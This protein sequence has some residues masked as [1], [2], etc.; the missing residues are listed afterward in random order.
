MMDEPDLQPLEARLGYTFKDRKLLAMA[1]THPSATQSFVPDGCDN[2]RLEFLGDAVLQL[3][4]AH[5][6]YIRY[7][8]M[9]EG[10]LTKARARMV[11]ERTLSDMARKVDLGSELIMSRG[12][13]ANG[14]RERVSAL[15][16]A[17][18]AAV[19]AVYMDSDFPTALKVIECI[20]GA[21]IG[22]GAALPDID[23]PKGEL[24]E[25]VQATSPDAPVYR[26]ESAS[27]P[28]HDR[29]F[30]STVHH[31]GRELGRGSGKTKKEAESAAAAAALK[32][33]RGETPEVNTTED[34]GV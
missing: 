3:A 10:P 28:D 22:E 9:A 26:L 1:V 34:P 19:G 31:G 18:E 2:Q 23:N 13:E 29:L 21:V 14:G 16:D 27:G 20:Y 25:L 33:L 5:M 15:A 17:F 32:L 6:L 24:Q 12:E 4:F 8:D 30:E 7:S 11:N